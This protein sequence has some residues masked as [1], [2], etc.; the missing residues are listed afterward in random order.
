VINE[1]QIEHF[2]YGW[3]NNIDTPTTQ[4]IQGVPMYRKIVLF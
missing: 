2:D 4:E 1:F 3:V